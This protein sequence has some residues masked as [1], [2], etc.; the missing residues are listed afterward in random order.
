VVKIIPEGK[1]A[2]TGIETFTMVF[3]LMLLF[4]YVM[5]AY[6]GRRR[7]TDI[8]G[9][10]FSAQLDCYK[11]ASLI[12]RVTSNGIGFMEDVSFTTHM[13]RIYGNTG[14]IEVQF[15]RTQ[16][17]T[18]QYYCTFQATNITNSTDST[19][20]VNGNYMVVNEGNKVAFYK[21]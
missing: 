1:K 16:G 19:F 20:F 15:D 17:D 5:I 13:I 10:M 18:N 21:S 2:Q 11:M 3:V 14:G 9:N 4:V 7:D 6:T 12:N 8:T